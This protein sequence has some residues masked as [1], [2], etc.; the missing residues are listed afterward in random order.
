MKKHISKHPTD[1]YRVL[2]EDIFV[3]EGTSPIPASV[4][5][6]GVSAID[7]SIIGKMA[8]LDM[9]AAATAGTSEDSTKESFDQQQEDRTLQRLPSE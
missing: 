4:A 3:T 2:T 9:G 7:P 6:S 5:A 1:D 8:N